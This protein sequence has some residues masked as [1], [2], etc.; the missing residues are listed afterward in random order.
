MHKNDQRRRSNMASINF[1]SFFPMQ[2]AGLIWIQIQIQIFVES[3]A[4]PQ[5]PCEDDEHVVVSGLID[6][7]SAQFS[8]RP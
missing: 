5:E 8:P 3:S 6:G 2:L 1:L 4:S 7:L